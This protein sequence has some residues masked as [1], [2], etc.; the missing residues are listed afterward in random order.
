MNK[1]K[2][3]VQNR[4]ASLSPTVHK[5]VSPSITVIGMELQGIIMGSNDGQTNTSSGNDFT[6][7]GHFSRSSPAGL[8]DENETEE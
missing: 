2:Q 5:Y 6:S 7:G 8:Y 3:G 1:R 4:T